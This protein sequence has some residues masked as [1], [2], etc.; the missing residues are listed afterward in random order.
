MACWSTKATLSLKRVKI[1]EKLP[2]RTYRYSP[3]L[4]RRTYV[5][6]PTPCGL[7]FPKIRVRNPTPKKPKLQSLLSQERAKLRTS[8]KSKSKSDTVCQNA[9]CIRYCCM[10]LCIIRCIIIIGDMNKPFASI[11]GE[12]SLSFTDCSESQRRYEVYSE[13]FT[14]TAVRRYY[15]AYNQVIGHACS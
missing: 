4:F 15:K 3:T 14:S 5:P 10:H 6:S 12:G 13:C 2:W 7:L 1:E 11:L 8:Y 9:V